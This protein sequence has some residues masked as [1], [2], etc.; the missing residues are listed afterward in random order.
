MSDKE[1]KE[2]M[3][4][5]NRHPDKFLEKYEYKLQIEYAKIRRNEMIK[6]GNNKMSIEK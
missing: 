2:R 6:R 5:I 1:Y 4:L 3:R